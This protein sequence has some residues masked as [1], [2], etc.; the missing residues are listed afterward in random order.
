VTEVPRLE[1]AFLG[2]R[3][4]GQGGALRT[5]GDFHADRGGI[6]SGDSCGAQHGVLRKYFVVNLGDQVILAVGLAAPHLP[7]LYRVHCHGIIPDSCWSTSRLP[8]GVRG[9]NPEKVTDG[10]DE[11]SAVALLR[12]GRREKLCLVVSS[13]A[14]PLAP[15]VRIA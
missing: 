14:N 3:V 7:E 4:A 9:V 5:L 1:G 8:G 11:T 13:P 15:A 2:K 12:F 10:Q 6:G